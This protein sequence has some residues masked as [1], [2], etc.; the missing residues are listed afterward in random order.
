MWKPDNEKSKDAYWI[1]LNY[2]SQ[3]STDLAIDALKPVVK[4]YDGKI[5]GEKKIRSC[6]DG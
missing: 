5:G 1:G 2:A 6:L 4:K 3:D